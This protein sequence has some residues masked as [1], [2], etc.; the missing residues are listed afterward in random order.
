MHF[1]G[2]YSAFGMCYYADVAMGSYAECL[3]TN[4]ILLDAQDNHLPSLIA[5]T[6]FKQVDIAI[7]S[8]EVTIYDNS[9]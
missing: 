3:V 6:D 2:I 1:I 9:R 4:K 8:T 5:H 7:V